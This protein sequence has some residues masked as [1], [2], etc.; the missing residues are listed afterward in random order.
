VR[1]QQHERGIHR[2]GEQDRNQQDRNQQDR[3]PG[4]PQTR[5]AIRL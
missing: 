3:G 4:P 5:A 2:R 1:C